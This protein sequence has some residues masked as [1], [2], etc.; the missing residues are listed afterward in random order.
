[1]T[2]IPAPPKKKAQRRRLNEQGYNARPY[3]TQNTE[4]IILYKRTWHSLAQVRRHWHSS[5]FM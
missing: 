1:M 2:I 3:T 4:V 5:M